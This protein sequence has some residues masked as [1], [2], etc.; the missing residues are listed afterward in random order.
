MEF[1]RGLVNEWT[2]GAKKQTTRDFHRNVAKSRWTRRTGFREKIHT[3]PGRD[4]RLRGRASAVVR[5]SGARQR[6]R[7]TIRCSS[8][9]NPTD[10][11]GKTWSDSPKAGDDHFEPAT[12]SSGSNDSHT[13]SGS[14]SDR[15]FRE[16]WIFLG[17]RTIEK[18]VDWVLAKEWLKNYRGWFLQRE[19]R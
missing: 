11:S 7:W 6:D 8:C 1:R 16:T 10:G 4:Q 9:K 12:H 19:T 5:G 3:W 14:R 15:G 13:V 17:G 2:T 18:R